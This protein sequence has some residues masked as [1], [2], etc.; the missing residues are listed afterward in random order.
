M[1]K[2][3]H[4]ITQLITSISKSECDLIIVFLVHTEFVIKKYIVNNYD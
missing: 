3:L 1:Y 4:L 2:V